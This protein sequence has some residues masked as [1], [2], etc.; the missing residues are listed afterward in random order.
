LGGPIKRDKL[1]IFGDY[2]GSRY[3]QP[4]T[5]GTITVLT[6]Q[7]R[8]GNF[9]RLPT[10]LFNPYSLDQN[11]NRIPFAGNVIPSNLFSRVATAVLASNLYP[12]PT[13]GA[14]LNNQINTTRSY[15]NGDQGD[16]KVDWNA[17]DKDHVFG[18]YSQSYV[19]APTLNS[20]PLIYN[21][22]GSYPIH[23]GVLDYTRTISPSFVNDVR[24]GVNY[25][26]GSFGTATGNL[27]NL[28]A[29]FGISGAISDILPSLTTP[30][31][32]ASGVGS[33]GG[34]NLFATTVIQYG[35]TAIIS[36]GRHTLQVGFEGF[37]ERI[38]T[39]EVNVGGGFTFNGQYTA[40]SGAT[41]GGGTGQPE[42]DF[43]LGLP[44]NVSA[45]VNA[46]DWGQRANIF[47][48]FVQD[49]WRV[50]DNL[51]LNLGVRYEIHTPW[52]EVYNRQAN[53]A[54]FT[55]QIETAGESTYYNNNRALYNQYNGPLNFQ[56]RVGV[57]WTPGGRKTVVRASYTMS[58]YM[59]GTGTYL[60]LPLNPPFTPERV[61][62]YTSYA[63]PPTTLDQ[64]FAA[65]G[66]PSNVYAGA[67]LRLWDPNVR[68][69]VSNQ[70]NF[71]LQH[72]FGN[73]TTLQA[74]YVG[75]K[76]SHLVV[77]Q[78][79]LQKQLLPDG[80]V[81]DSPYLA[82]NPGLQSVVGE[83]SGTESNGNQSYNAL[84]VT[85]QKRLAN[86]LQGQFAYTWS[87]CM[88]DS[89]GF[90]GEG[91]QAASASPYSQNLYNR[92]AEWGPCYY[93]LTQNVSAYFSYDLPDLPFGRQHSIGKNWNRT[94]DAVLGG[95][96]INSILSFHD[97]FPLTVS[98]PDSSGTNSQ[99]SRANC[100]APAA[101]YGTQNS[102]VGGY[103]WFD[104]SAFGPAVQGTFGTC[105]VGT[106]RGPGLSTAD[107]SF[108]KIFAI[109]ERQH[110]EF[111]SEF[112]NFTNTPILQAP[113]TSLGSNLGLI[114]SAQG[115]RN[116][117]FGLK[118][119]F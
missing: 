108:L 31:G 9:S 111:R 113:T 68:P 101:V 35:D 7:E 117:Q 5:S 91:A 83:V 78:A 58:S 37:R 105:G 110:L 57:A 28:P 103:Q 1:F 2:Q 54:P 55:G 88:T 106:V 109:T 77:A 114:Q 20:Q 66:S 92:A 21:S 40:A 69:A 60:R 97:G 41:F 94:V 64:G 74:A 95:W 87:K 33:S 62:D 70:W 52:V 63:L 61:V 72:E 104:A 8:Q 79:Y 30:G 15:I 107:V 36:K 45:G 34:L 17:S 3:D 116:I 38:D 23:N 43:L 24:F 42:A 26:V 16:V 73:S 27:G 12:S 13:N 32:N 85:L 6:N 56:P 49:N 18:R 10:Q 71:T 86:G 11:E 76:N 65:I 84:Q 81:A 48:A 22:Y 59:E 99:G 102:A 96:Q 67:N 119:S 14:L 25:T 118:Y 51:T 39:L 75:Q 50:S 29:E 82:G 47:A 19:D 98:A 80:T 93:D 100:L 115:A 90:Y 112:I 53:F 46:G 4:A 44:S 89:T